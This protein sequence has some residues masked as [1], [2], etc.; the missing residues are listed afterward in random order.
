MKFLRTAHLAL[1]IVVC[2]GAVVSGEDFFSGDWRGT[3]VFVEDSTKSP[4]RILVDG[5]D[6]EDYYC[7]DGEWKTFKTLEVSR[8]EKL[9][10]N[11][12]LIW[13]DKGAVWTET[14][15]FSLSYVNN[16]TMALIWTRHVNNKTKGDAETWH[17]FG[18][19]TLKRFPLNASNKC[20]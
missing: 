17:T 4:M 5:D 11:A 10:N 12:L 6:V 8:F 2:T 9:E 7:I 14:Q 1:A 19:G 20:D 15:T 16:D 18:H 13:I 3:V